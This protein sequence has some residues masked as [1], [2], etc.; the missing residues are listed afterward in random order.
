MILCNPRDIPHHTAKAICPLFFAEENT[1]VQRVVAW[2]WSL[3]KRLVSFVWIAWK[4]PEFGMFVFRLQD[5]IICSKLFP[6]VRSWLL[7]RVRNLEKVMG[8]ANRKKNPWIF[9]QF[10]FQPKL[11]WL[12]MKMEQKIV[13]VFRVFFFEVKVFIPKQRAFMHLDT[14]FTFLDRATVSGT[15]SVGLGWVGIGEIKFQFF[16]PYI[17]GNVRGYSWIFCWLWMGQGKQWCEGVKECTWS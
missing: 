2:W 5:W 7:F 4:S 12:D 1:P 10:F 6:S 3:F 17:F 11:P 8:K 9:G 13:K 15:C 16:Q 14:L